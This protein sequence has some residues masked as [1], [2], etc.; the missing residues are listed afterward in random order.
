MIL[1]FQ[2]WL[3]RSSQRS[4]A[5]DYN[6]QTMHCYIKIRYQMYTDM[7]VANKFRWRILKQTS[8]CK[9]I[10]LYVQV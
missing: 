6:Q 8:T 7:G 4:K 2:N 1:I 10:I 3:M 9:C 5:E